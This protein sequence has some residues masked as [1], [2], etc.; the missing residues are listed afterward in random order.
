MSKQGQALE[1][2]FHGEPAVWLKWGAYEAAVL[3]EVGA[4][5]IAFRDI[6]KGYHFLHEPAESEMAE[7]KA[8]PGTHGIPVLFPPNRYQDGTFTM[9]GKTY[10]FPINEPSTGNHLHGF[11][12]TAAWEVLDYGTLKTESYV[13]LQIAVDEQHPIYA[14]LP[15]RFAITL[16]YSLNDQ[17]LFQHISVHNR[18]NDAMPCLIGF[19]TA[20][21]APFAPQSAASDYSF[22]L[23]AGK[24]WELDE[25]M[26]P[27]GQFQP[28]SSNEEK[29]KTTGA[30]P[31]FEPLDNHYTVEARNGRNQMELTD[32]REQVTLVYDA[33]TAYK[34]WMVWNSNASGQFFCP[35]PQLNL[36]NA[37]NVDLPADEI[38]LVSLEPNGIWEETS[39]LYVKPAAK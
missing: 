16:R 7:F 6:E 19:H 10:S 13:L 27:T 28:L 38:G 36:V 34:Q 12:H 37:P 17:G 21:N 35:E 5:L 32:A 26:L 11:V 22:T 8:R 39:R 31:Y 33:G 9:N 4:N 2:A 30:S 23:T 1:Q 29:L 24:R 18:G 15:H 3:P 20:I 14:Y 25:R